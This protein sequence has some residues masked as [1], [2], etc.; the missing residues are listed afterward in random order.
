VAIMLLPAVSIYL[1]DR[2]RGDLPPRSIA[3]VCALYLAGCMFKE[4][5][6]V[7]PALL[8]AAELTVIDDGRGVR[9]RLGDA[10][11]R[12]PYFLMAL[13]GVAFVA[14]RALELSDH[15]LGGFQPFTP[16]NSLHIG[17]ADRMLTAVGVV[18]QWLRLFYWPVR[19]VSEYGP[20]EIEIAQGFSISLIP[21]FLLLFATLALGVILRRR[22]PVISFGIAFVCVSLLPSS[23]FIIPAG[24]VLAERTLFLPSVGAM[25]V[26]GGA[27]VSLAKWLS[28]SNYLR[29]ETNY[30]LAGVLA[31]VLL[32]GAVHSHTRTKVWRDNETLFHNAVMD[33]PDSYRAHYMLGAW[34][35]EK[36]RKRIGE[37]EY[38]KAMSLFP[39]DPFLAYNLAEQY[40]KTNMCRPAIPLYRWSRALDP[41]FPLGRTAY[42][43]CLL[44][45]GRFADAKAAA[46]EAMRG[47]GDVKIA[48]RVIF[49]ADSARSADNA[50]HGKVPRLPQKTVELSGKNP[51]GQSGK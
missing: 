48:R 16:F 32:A 4:H 14:A 49:L 35:F 31:V 45:D 9:E 22:A 43:I 41:D 50:V 33:A 21:G 46:F 20:P 36:Q 10:S 29:R 6:I 3:A 7:L 19:L 44:E 13:I 27:I 40:R 25:L 42:A 2:A 26:L 5:A 34:S 8:G 23:N 17:A 12:L 18:P 38:K 28:E 51:Q 30:A 15:G 11:L 39:Y 37:L 1:R 24:I 47:G